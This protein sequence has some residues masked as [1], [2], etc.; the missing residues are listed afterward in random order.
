MIA[1][2]AGINTITVEVTAED[3]QT[4]KTYSITVTR[5]DSQSDPI[6]SDATLSGLT[7]SDVS[8]G[9]FVSGTASYSASIAWS[10]S[11]TT[12]TP[13]ASHSEASYAVK[14]SGITDS[15]GTLP[16]QVGDNV[17][18]VEVT[19]EDE[20][21]T[22]TYSVTV[23]RADPPSTDATLQSLTVNG[24]A[25]GSRGL[26]QFPTKSQFGVIFRYTVTEATV[27]AVVN[28]PG[29]SYVFKIEGV[30]D[31]DGTFP[32]AVGTSDTTIEVTAE[33]NETTRTYNLFI[34]RFAFG[35]S[36][37]SS[38]RHVE[39]STTAIATYAV[40]DAGDATI[41]WSL[42][43]DDSGHFSINALGVLSFSSS[44]DYESPEDANLDNTYLVTIEASDE[45]TTS[46]LDVTITVTDECRSAGEPPCAPGSPNV[47]PASDTSLRVTWSTPSTPSGTSITG[48]DLQFRESDGGG[49]WI[50]QS[51]AGTDRSHTIENIIKDTSYEVQVSAT[52]DSSGYG[53][54]SESGTGRPGGGGGGGTPPPTGPSFTDGTS[55]SRSVAVPA[56]SGADVGDPVVASHPANL[57]ITYS[58]IASVPVLFTV[59]EMTGQIR[60]VQ[61]V[62][63][64]SGQTYRVTLRA[65]DST[66]IE[67]YIDVVV[68]VEPHQYDLN[69]NG[70][71]EKEEVI[72]AINDYLFGTGDDQI[73][74]EQVLEIITLYLFG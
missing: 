55:T 39:N 18:S 10:V 69:S 24:G 50:P 25:I 70:A 27:S 60:L 61:G 54:W 12:V 31:D 63:P 41:V 65:T 5:L 17:I 64:V 2:S 42:S 4:T 28:H 72:E 30:V 56:P 36:G 47:S 23:T 34:K 37:V 15:D 32:L 20:S 9:T 49:S 3:G 38:S 1:L 7:L 46:T 68:D 53:E 33:D 74:K 45:S 26:L 52:N 40:D 58:L 14:L 51:V 21:T 16:L 48:Y 6:S 22:Q 19:A 35:V 59:D 73:T 62:S 71:F 57:D 44:L 13:T 66:G 8:F 43:G 11:E 67:A 29:A